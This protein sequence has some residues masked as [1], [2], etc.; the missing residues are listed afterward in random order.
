MGII[1]FVGLILADVTARFG[2]LA[3]AMGLHF[4]NN[5][6]MLFVGAKGDLSGLSLYTSEVDLKSTETGAGMM[7]YLGVMMVCY[8]IFMLIMRRRRL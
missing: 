8:L 2:S 3:P 4:T 6:A 1:T 5:A 7:I